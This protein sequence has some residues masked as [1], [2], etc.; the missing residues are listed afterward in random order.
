M[1]CSSFA[2]QCH[3]QISE[4]ES[5]YYSCF[6]Y[7]SSDTI[8]DNKIEKEAGEAFGRALASNISLETLN[9]GVRKFIKYGNVANLTGITKKCNL[10]GEGAIPIAEALKMNKSLLELRLWVCYFKFLSLLCL[11]ICSGMI[12]AQIPP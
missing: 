11:N 3:P 7:H 5:N 12:F 2:H 8:Q 4:F 1:S 10:L 6:N 9:L